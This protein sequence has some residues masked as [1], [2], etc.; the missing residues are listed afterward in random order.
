MADRP[1][2]HLLLSY[3][4]LGSHAS[5]F[6]AE[7]RSI[8]QSC[9]Y[10]CAT[11]GQAVTT[12]QLGSH[13][14]IW[15]IVPKEAL[16]IKFCRTLTGKSAELHKIIHKR[17]INIA[18]VQE[19]RWVGT[20][21]RDV[22]GFKLWYSVGTGD[23]NGVGIFVDRD[24]RELVVEVRR[25]NDRLMSLN[26]VVEGFTINVISVYAPQVGLDQE[27]KRQ[28]WEDLDEVVHNIPHAEKIF[29]GGDFNGHIGVDARGYDDVHGGFGFGDR[30]ERAS[31]LFDF[32]SAFDLVIANSSFPK[33]EEH[34]VT[35]RF[36][37]DPD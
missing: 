27:A 20:R 33:R 29:I 21:A 17:K 4:R 1:E 30:K 5:S 18:C 12:N 9:S 35:F 25:V 8:G 15:I 32:P 36:I 24:L 6:T 28:F 11:A 26:L 13:F 7:L 3:G 34:L 16:N 19:T 2:M 10:N 23:K 22:D 14:T 31:T 37:Q